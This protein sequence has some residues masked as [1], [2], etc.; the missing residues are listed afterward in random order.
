MR[1]GGGE[2]EA[3]RLFPC[4]DLTPRSYY[5]QRGA[6]WVLYN[7]VRRDK[8]HRCDESITYSTHEYFT[9]LDNLV[10]LLERW[11]VRT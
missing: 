5:A 2:Q 8:M 3:S 10:P 9:F 1:E 11:Q 7:Y 4:D 6:Y